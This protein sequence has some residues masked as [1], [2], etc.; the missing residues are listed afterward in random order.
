MKNWVLLILALTISC[1]FQAQSS[2]LPP[3]QSAP[4]NTSS[5]FEVQLYGGLTKIYC[6]VNAVNN[7]A[8][9]GAS[10]Y[11]KVT[12]YFSV[13][14][15]VHKG[16]YSGGNK[17]NQQLYFM[18][19]TNKFLTTSLMARIYP[20]AIPNIDANILRRLYL[21]V[22]VGAHFNRLNAYNSQISNVGYLE[23]NKD[24]NFFIPMEA[25]ISIPIYKW[26]SAK[27]FEK[28]NTLSIFS[29]YRYNL[30]FSD[31]WDGYTP[32]VNA[33]SHNDGSGTVLFGIEFEF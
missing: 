23:N 9:V 27:H 3:M 7:E 16:K 2:Y 5:Q 21:N 11:Y 18:E 25:G 32:V 4:F 10:I 19:F 1:K 33:N 26:P 28:M 29:A 14:F 31:T 12:D 22:G 20:F 17:D 15:D 8:S 30:G 6:D 24:A 13:G